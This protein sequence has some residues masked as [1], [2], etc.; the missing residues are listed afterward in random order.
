MKSGQLDDRTRLIEIV[1]KFHHCKVAV[2]GDLLA[3]EFIYGDITRVSREA[4]VLILE[5]RKTA[6]M[7]G[8][9][10]NS[11]ANLRALGACPVPLGVLGRDDT[12]DRLLAL[13]KK[14]G[15]PLSGIVR[16]ASYST[17][18]KSRI[19]AGGVHTR[20]QQIVRIDRG[21]TRGDHSEQTMATLDRHLKKALQSCAGLLV[22]D[23]GYGAAPPSLLD[24][25]IPRASRKK[26]II[27]VDSRSR[28]ASFSGITICTPNQEELEQAL[29]VT[30]L[31]DEETLSPSGRKLLRLVQAESVL[32]TRGARGM[33]LFRRG[34]KMTSIPAYG[35]GDVA[36]VTGAGDTVI[37]T[38][39]LALIAGADHHEASRL[40]NY[41]AGLVVRK[42]GTATITAA[43]LT[44]AINLDLK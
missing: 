9:G 31:D 7:P 36:D 3:D 37:A 16:R 18:S 26:H 24:R 44:T 13:F 11:I 14:M 15:C 42:A 19:L 33:S 1:K 2:L 41:A 23:Y 27:A 21:A 32:I 6:V 8:G 12:G 5:H 43:E 25:C 20:R 34:R 35:T 17:P 10:G 28:I 29:G 22:A 38:V 40:A 30:G 39:T 4:P